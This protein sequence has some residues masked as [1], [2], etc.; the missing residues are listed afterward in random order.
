M[1]AIAQNAKHL[2]IIFMVIMVD[3]KDAFCTVISFQ[4]MMLKV[5]LK[6]IGK[7]KRSYNQI[8]SSL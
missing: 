1:V 6:I 3:C 8:V 5:K 4:L 7:K 2:Q